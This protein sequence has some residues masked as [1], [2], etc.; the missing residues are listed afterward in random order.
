MTKHATALLL[1]LYEDHLNG[2]YP[3]KIKAED[4]GMTRNELI[5]AGKELKSQGFL[6]DFNASVQGNDGKN[7]ICFGKLTGEAIEYAK[8]FDED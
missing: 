8:S 4:L 1:W 7:I 5:Q 3:Q 6:P 2:V